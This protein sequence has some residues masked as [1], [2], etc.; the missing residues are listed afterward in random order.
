MPLIAHS[1]WRAPAHEAGVGVRDGEAEVVVAVHGEDDVAQ[2]GDEPVQAVE[3]RRV[4]VGHGVADGVGDV[5][6]RRALFDRGGDDLGGV[7]E[8]G[9]RRVHRR[10][11]DV[12]DEGPRVRH[13]RAGL[14]EDVLARG[15]ELVDDVDVRR[16][17]ERVDAR[18]RGVAYSSRGGLHIGCLSSSEAGDDRA[19]DLAGDRLHRLEVAGRRDREAGLDDVDAEAGELVG[20]LELLA[21]VQRD[22]GRLLAVA[23]RGVEDADVRGIDAAHDVDSPC[24]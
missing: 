10:E 6:R 5:D 18:V 19:L 7:L 12:V 9:A 23:Q 21:G 17:D 2:L 4:L 20:D 3:E 24:F 8:L 16:R 1:T 22:A 14:R 11:L 13:G 15:A